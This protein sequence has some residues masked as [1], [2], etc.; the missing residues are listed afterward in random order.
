MVGGR[1]QISR[2]PAAAA[3]AD[4]ERHLDE[5]ALRCRS[6]AR[7]ECRRGLRPWADPAVVPIGYLAESRP[8]GHVLSAI[9]A[10]TRTSGPHKPQR[11]GGT[12]KSGRHGLATLR[13]ATAVLGLLLLA[14]QA[15][16]A[17]PTTATAWLSGAALGALAVAVCAGLGEAWGLPRAWPRIRGGRRPWV[18]AAA[19]TAAAN[20]GVVQTW[21]RPWG[22]VAGGDV[23]PP[24]GTAWLGHIFAP[25]LWQGS[26]L[27]AP[28]EL[29]L[30][31]PWAGVVAVTHL[32]GLSGTVAE[33]AWIS[34]LAAG[35]G[36]AVL[37]LARQI[38]IASAPAA[39]G[40][41]LYL[42]SPV[43]VTNGL[44][45]V[46]LAAMVLVAA[47]PALILAVARGAVPVWQGVACLA[48]GTPLLGYTYVV[49]PLS[50]GVV[51]ALALAALLAPWIGGRAAAGRTARL[52]AFGTPAL[53]LT[54]LYWTVP[55]LLFFSGVPTHQIAA[56]SSWTWS[57]S[58]ATVRNAFWLNSYWAWR[59]PSYFPYALTFSQLPLSFLRF[60]PA[61]VGFGALL[62]R[63]GTG[64]HSAALLRIT[65]GTASVT[66]GTIFLSTGTHLPGAVLFDFLYRLPFGWVLKQ[67]VRFLMVADL[68]YAILVGIT[69]Q[70]VFRTGSVRRVMTVAGHRT[71]PVIAGAITLVALML[72][73]AYPLFTGAVVLGSHD[74]YPSEFLARAEAHVSVPVYWEEMA[75]FINTQ[76]PPGILWTLPVDDYYQMPYR[77]YYG[78]DGF[79][80][81][82]ISRS[83]L[84]PVAEGYAPSKASLLTAVALGQRELL[85]GSWTASQDVLGALG[86]RLV[87]VRGDVLANYPGRTFSDPALL[88]QALA[89]DPHARL[90][91][92]RGP[93][94]L[95]ADSIPQAGPGP[96]YVTVKS[97]NA[98]LRLLGL[99]PP[100][101]RLVSAHPMTGIP[102]ITEVP[103]IGE[104]THQGSTF[105]R[106][107]ALPAGRQTVA[108]LSAVG[109]EHRQTLR[110]GSSA[111]IGGIDVSLTA[112][113]ESDLLH[114]QAPSEGSK[115]VDANFAGGLW[116]P[117]S[118]CHDVTGPSAKAQ[119]HA[120]VVAGRGPG[121]SPALR[122]SAGL[123]T[124]C[125]FQH[126]TWRSGSVLIGISARRVSGSGPRMCLL[127]APIGRCATLPPFA[128]GSG[129]H[130][131]H[132]VVTPGPGVKTLTIYLYADSPGSGYHTIDEYAD[133]QA[134]GLPTAAPIAVRSTPAHSSKALFLSTNG[135]AY[136][137]HWTALPP[138]QHVLVD[139]VTNGWLAS[140]SV[141]YSY[142]PAG[143]LEIVQWTSAIVGVL[144]AF[145]LLISRAASRRRRR[146]AGQTNAGVA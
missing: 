40:A 55:S 129:W 47:G 86:I 140:S 104:W 125:E 144:L 52:V 64:R 138:A 123:D 76:A 79:I 7:P 71:A 128:I 78:H 53:I 6:L 58:R 90:L 17:R 4:L 23:A 118:D 100:G 8:E 28:A 68:G 110:V 32:V 13:R 91:A 89:R 63:A 145:V 37:A 135:Q 83:V 74:T 27:G 87:L 10:R 139:G 36:L 2:V 26:S 49:P 1:R 95:Y 19:V 146:R 106:S 29:E 51:A 94:R 80:A 82:L 103:A 81:Q 99:L 18:M 33:D 93:L 88:A 126:L 85:A 11:A 42:L 61:L 72:V 136:S 62:L 92:V 98:D 48:L 133:L 132:T 130:T 60:L 24:I 16:I 30:K 15:L 96:S 67:P 25:W 73:P 116:E 44:N 107:V 34:A 41:V 102:S 134:I 84:D 43:V 127:E 113:G 54:S 119:L 21:F 115:L 5:A 3:S 9:R 143:K 45:P 35:A 141:R 57:E 114:L 31:L 101:Y 105:T 122:L 131:Y 22:A 108:L 112:R 70:T 12:S 20:V 56:L 97:S 142:S 120:T 111:M 69:L 77:W 109:I 38:G 117:V 121:S 46:Y 137:P 66:L 39:V 59:Y 75:K 14:E 50:V 65:L 124:A